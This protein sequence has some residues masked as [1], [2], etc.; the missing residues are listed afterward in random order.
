MGDIATDM[1]VVGLYLDPIA[2]W[3]LCQKLAVSVKDSNQA[4]PI[5]EATFS[6]GSSVRLEAS[7]GEI[8]FFDS[9]GHWVETM[10]YPVG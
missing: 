9:D 10:A 8:H 7:C 4:V 5:P 6:D 3:E 1:T 2:L